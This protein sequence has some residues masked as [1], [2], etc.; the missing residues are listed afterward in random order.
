MYLELCSALPIQL[1][2]GDDSGET[3]GDE[4]LSDGGGNEDSYRRKM[5]QL[6]DDIFNKAG[7]NIKDAQQKQKQYYDNKRGRKKLYCYGGLNACEVK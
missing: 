2:I 4:T 5:N 3:D 1:E 7:K 6:R